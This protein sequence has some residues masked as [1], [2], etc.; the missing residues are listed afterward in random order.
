MP[1]LMPSDVLGYAASF[2]HGADAAQTSHVVR[3]REYPAV[4]TQPAIL[5]Y[6]PLGDVEQADV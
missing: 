1:S 4:L 5:V 3:Y 2:S 6:D